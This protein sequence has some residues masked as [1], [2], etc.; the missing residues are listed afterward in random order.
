M[1]LT[2]ET[3]FAEVFGAEIPRCL[4]FSSTKSTNRDAFTSTKV[5][6]L[7]HLADLRGEAVRL[8]RQKLAVFTW[9]GATVSVL[10][11]PKAVYKSEMRCVRVCVRAWR[12]SAC[13]RAWRASACA[14]PPL[15]HLIYIYVYYIYT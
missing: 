13:V 11:E 14:R 10:G 9:Q 3:G 4:P 12:A 5:Q 7:T 8:H 2:L 15:P 6:I 1:S